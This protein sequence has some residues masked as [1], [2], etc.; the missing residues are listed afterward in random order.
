MQTSGVENNVRVSYFQYDFA[1]H[2]GA[3][4]AITVTGDGIPSG[5]IIT[6]GMIHVNTAV[7]S[8]GSAT[9][10]IEALT[11]A[12]LLAATAKASLTLNALVSAIPKSTA[13]TW[14]RATSAINSLDFT[15]AVAA[16]TAGKITV[17]LTWCLGQ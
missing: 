10:A 7:T 12:D 1:K 4:G 5:A 11:T 3:T 17:A 14:I 16:L 2:G 15:V 9:V 6:D 13:A 8:A